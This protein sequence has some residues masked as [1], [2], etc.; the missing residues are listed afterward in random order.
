MHQIILHLH[1]VLR[2]LV[3]ILMLVAIVRS[4]LGINGRKG[5]GKADEKW[6]FWAML[7]LHIQATL[8]IVL[9]VVSPIIKSAMQDMG[10]AMGNSVQRFFVVEHA[11]AMLLAVVLVTIGRKK[12]LKA[13]TDQQKHKKILI[14]FLLALVIIFLSIPWPFMPSGL[15]RGWV[16]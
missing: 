11:V 13:L 10:A 15:G 12:A 2:Y 16:S 4:F 9:Y 14:F 1:S 7:S 8:G 6:A 5:F 3:L